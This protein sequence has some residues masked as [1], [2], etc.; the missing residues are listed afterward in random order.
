MTLQELWKTLRVFEQALTAISAMVV[1]I[2]LLG[3]LTIMLASLRE[4][5]REMA[6]LRAVGA[7]PGTIFG[8]LLSEALLLTVVGAFL[9]YSC[10]MACN[11][12]WPALSSRRQG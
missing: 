3:M 4:R 12:R 5:R 11:G 10:Y 7:G 2:G 6:V 9:A 1:L 8:L